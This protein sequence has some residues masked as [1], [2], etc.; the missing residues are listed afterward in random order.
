MLFRITYREPDGIS[1]TF[2]IEADDLADARR[3]AARS[4]DLPPGARVVGAPTTITPQVE[5]ANQDGQGDPPEP[6]LKTYNGKVLPAFFQNPAQYA[7]FLTQPDARKQMVVDNNLQNFAELN[8]YIL[9]QGQLGVTGEQGE[10]GGPGGVPSFTEFIQEQIQLGNVDPNKVTFNADGTVTTQ[11]NYFI[12]KTGLGTFENNDTDTVAGAGGLTQAEIDAIVKS[13]TMDR[14]SP[15]LSERER[16]RFLEGVTDFGAFAEGLKGTPLEGLREAGG[17]GRRF[18]E[19]Q[20]APAEAAYR[21]SQILPLITGGGLTQG[22][23]EALATNDETL[24]AALR[25]RISGGTLSDIEAALLAEY[26]SVSNQPQTFSAFTRR[27]LGQ[28]PE[29]SRADLLNQFREA[30]ALDEAAT[31]IGREFARP[32]SQA[33][34][35]QIENFARSAFASQYSPII[36]QALAAAL[37]QNAFADYARESLAP[38]PGGGTAEQPNFLQFI[39]SR[40]GLI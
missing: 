23:A 26:D 36:Q 33:N 24:N 9:A 7:E 3:K 5:T 18:A 28:G 29:A 11:P 13:Q 14:T 38:T 35:A 20:F 21:A 22:A 16:E 4:N 10:Q 8:D 6:E 40:Y 30:A 37:P 15:G 34:A 39:G 27:F 1:G 12:N 32:S 17:F 19:Q 31:G 25:K 2:E